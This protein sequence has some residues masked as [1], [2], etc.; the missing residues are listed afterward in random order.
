MD[1]KVDSGLIRLEREKRAWTQEHLAKAAGLSVRTI[2][3]IERTGAASFES[4][5]ALA[6]VLELS[7]ADLRDPTRVVE[8]GDDARARRPV[9]GL[10]ARLLLA[11]ASGAACGI[12]FDSSLGPLDW[13]E[14]VYGGYA[15]GGLLFA[16]GVLW[17]L[18]TW[19]RGAARRAF[20]LVLAS[21][22]SYFLAVWTVLE[23]LP[24][25]LD[26]ERI[27]SPQAFVLASAV[28]ATVVL[29]AARMLLPLRFTKAFWALG[30]LASVLGGVGMYA[31]GL[32]GNDFL[33]AAGFAWWHAAI[34]LALHFGGE[35]SA[36]GNRIA[37]LFD[38]K[39]R[40]ST[41]A[42]HVLAVGHAAR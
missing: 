9:L 25:W 41:A 22:S 17:P 35:T 4:V 1:V 38:R 33:A 16:A 3:R 26:A 37:K 31:V 29:T 10:P 11:L 32:A 7:V 14:P 13:L 18:L 42:S 12:A 40:S 39:T 20:V 6:A 24:A 27:E 21:A 36:G 30:A 8:Q 15:L 2:Q 23:M 5:R 19:E 34:C 28:G